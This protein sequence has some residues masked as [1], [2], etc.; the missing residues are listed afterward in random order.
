MNSCCFRR[1]CSSIFITAATM[2]QAMFGP[3]FLMCGVAVTRWQ[4]FTHDDRCRNSVIDAAD[5]GIEFI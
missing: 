1:V 5:A 3:L 4:E 2:A